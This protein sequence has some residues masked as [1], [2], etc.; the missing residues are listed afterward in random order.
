[1]SEQHRIIQRLFIRAAEKHG[2]TAFLALHLA[3]PY[4]ELRLYIQGEAM[5]L[6]VILLKVV[7]L[8]LEE[9]P[10]IR[11]EFSPDLWA[12]LALPK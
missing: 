2:S 3:I 10:A 6:E 7:D 11:S 8:I 4:S 1:M 9:L 12:S 5:P